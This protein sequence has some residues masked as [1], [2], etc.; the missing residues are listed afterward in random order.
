MYK[1]LIYMYP[2]YGMVLSIAGSISFLRLQN[3]A[4][5]CSITNY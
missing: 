3:P 1:Y 5:R 2:M 4:L